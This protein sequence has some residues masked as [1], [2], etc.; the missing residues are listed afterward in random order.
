MLLQM[1]LFHS[2]WWLEI[3]ISHTFF[4]SSVNGHLGC[5]HILAIVSSVAVSIEEHVPFQIIALPVYMPRSGIAGSC[6]KM[7]TITMF[8]QHNFGSSHQNTREKHKKKGNKNRIIGK[9]ETD[10]SLFRKK[11]YGCACRKSKLILRLI[12]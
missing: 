10:I 4:H 2:S 8:M 7:P 3:C 6:A 5:L 12:F 1:T 9:K 11:N